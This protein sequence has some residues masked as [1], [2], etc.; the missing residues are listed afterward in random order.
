M[1]MPT[2]RNDMMERTDVICNYNIK[3]MGNKN[4]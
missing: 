3:L 4:C 1:M 2:D